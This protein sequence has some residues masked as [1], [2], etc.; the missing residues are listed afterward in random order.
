MEEMQAKWSEAT[1]GRWGE[2]PYHTTNWKV[3]AAA[4]CWVLRS[5]VERDPDAWDGSPFVL[6]SDYPAHAL[7]ERER[8]AVCSL[9]WEPIAWS[10]G[11]DMVMNGQHRACALRV[12]AALEVPVLSDA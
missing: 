2:C 12:S 1:A 8:D 3:A 10:V 5:Q 11:S 7:T 9:L 6:A 4:A